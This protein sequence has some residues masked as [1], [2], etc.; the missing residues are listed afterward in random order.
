MARWLWGLLVSGLVGVQA[1]VVI[2][3]VCYDP[4]GA[5]AGLEWVELV[6]NGMDPVDLGG[7]LLDCNGPNLALPALVLGPGQTLLIHTNVAADLPPAGLEL[8]F[9]AASLGNTHGFVGLWSGEQ[10]PTNLQDYLQYGSVGHSW[11]SQ[12]AEVGVWPLDAFLPDVEQGHS[13]RRQGPGRGPQYW[14]DEDNPQPGE[15]VTEVGAREHG[16]PA[17]PRLGEVWPNPFNPETR[18]T[19]HLPALMPVRLSLV[20]LRGGEVRVLEDGLLP[21]GSHERR[22]VLDGEAA[23]CYFLR[24]QAGGR[25][26]VRKILLVK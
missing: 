25:Q 23:G 15:A 9:A 16:L 13:L 26:E 14:L 3:E 1:A 2:Q 11:E 20:D 10:D 4:E 7:W 8:W 17:Q 12:A 24:L 18:V 5:D 6:N 19:F 21:G 22:L